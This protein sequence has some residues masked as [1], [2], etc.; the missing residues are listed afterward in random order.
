MANI[1]AG[2]VVIERLLLDVEDVR[3][4]PNQSC[5]AVPITPIRTNV[6][7]N[8]SHFEVLSAPPG[9]ERAHQCV[10]VCVC[11]CERERERERES[12]N[13]WMSE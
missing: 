11:V 5:G 7:V 8:Q 10:C 2:S 1:A 12:E 13:E 4:A 3:S 9:G 6:V